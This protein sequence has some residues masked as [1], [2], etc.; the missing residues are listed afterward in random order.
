M[1]TQVEARGPA[2]VHCHLGAAGVGAEQH[3]MPGSS[4]GPP[5]PLLAQEFLEPVGGKGE[6]L[7]SQLHQVGILQPRMG[8]T[9]LQ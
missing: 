1:G 4:L 6:C 7:A 5:P 2:V 9:V 3:L 8:Q